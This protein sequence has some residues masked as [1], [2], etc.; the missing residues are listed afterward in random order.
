[1]DQFCE[2]KCA[3]RQAN[4]TRCTET[5]LSQIL[6]TGIAFLLLLLLSLCVKN[7]TGTFDFTFTHVI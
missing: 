3:E 2:R 1:M 6:T 4:T 7:H 5:P